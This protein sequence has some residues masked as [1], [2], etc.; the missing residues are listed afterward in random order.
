MFAPLARLFVPCRSRTR[1]SLRAELRIEALEDRT[2]PAGQLVVGVGGV[3]SPNDPEVSLRRTTAT[4]DTVVAAVEVFGG[5]AGDTR[6][7]VGDVNGDGV[8]DLIAGSGAGG[9]DVAIFDG[10]TAMAG[11]SAPLARFN[12]YA[13]FAGGIHVAAGDLDRDGFAEVM[14]TP[15]PGGR[16]HLK[17]FQFASGGQFSPTPRVLTSAYTFTDYNGEVR[18]AS[19]QFGGQ[20]FVVTASGAGV[21]GDIR[22]FRN[23][24]QIGQLADGAP[25]NPALLA[26]ALV[27][28][29]GYAGGLSVAA[30]DTDGDGNDEL[31]VSKND[32]A[33]TVEV[34][35]ASL[36]G[37]GLGGFGLVTA[38]EAFPGFLG[39][40]RL[41][42]A[43]VDGN[44]TVE[45]LTTTG[46]SGDPR[47]TPVKA[48]SRSGG[49]FNL[50]TAYY[51]NPGYVN[52]AWLAGRDFMATGRLSSGGFSGGGGAGGSDTGDPAAT[53]LIPAQAVYDIAITG[54]TY[55]GST[56][57]L[58]SATTFNFPI[59]FSRTGVVVVTETIDETNASGNGLNARD[60]A[61]VTGNIG[62]GGAGVL[63]FA[64]NSA[65]HQLFGGN[66]SQAASLDV[67]FVTTNT[68]AGT[69]RVT[70]DNTIAR[71]TQLN[72]LF[73][74]GG[75][76][77]LP[78]QIT[79]GIIDLQFTNGGRD[80][81]GSLTL[82]G[83]GFI[84]AGTAAV[85]ATFSGTRR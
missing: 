45:V 49:T 22:A 52:G 32:G 43:D 38:F 37:S 21:P 46:F 9:S 80:L 36:P 31:F 56:N 26:G 51:A 40:V 27:P 73:R 25:V 65:L 81:D 7:A 67:A 11:G 76:L 59:A 2:V 53:S 42:A 12:A 16:G 24:G 70:V 50:V 44:G 10:A 61:L 13:N 5:T 30:G 78:F 79:F 63:Q 17:V 20:N 66:F 34:Y 19:L 39:Q 47:G 74:T 64:T 77:A 29:G 1:T 4:G 55:S 69:I 57:F 18:V 54:N 14:T 62:V 85:Q 58:S 48:F 75:L 82:F 72:T 84:E 68:Q 71:T 15:G 41:G 35:A 3:T 23:A 60:I 33:A 8:D 28:F 6:V 83:E